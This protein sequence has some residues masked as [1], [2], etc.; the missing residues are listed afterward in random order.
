MMTKNYFMQINP[1]KTLYY[2]FKWL[3]F[4]IAK[5]MPILI[6][7]N[8]KLCNHRGGVILNKDIHF[9]MIN[10]GFHI[11]GFRNKK[12]DTFLVIRG[13][14]IFNGHC[15]IGKGSKIIIDKKGR[16]EFGKNFN[17][18]AGLNMECK[19]HVVFGD[20][21]V[22]SWDITIL[23]TDF[24]PI[25]DEH[26]KLINPNK[27]IQIGNHVWIGYN[28]KILKGITIPDNVIIASNTIVSKSVLQSGIIVGNEEYQLNKL[29][30]NI[31]W[32]PTDINAE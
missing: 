32:M 1:F 3:P 7:W 26:Q 19:K 11:G 5:K 25:Y 13:Q 28:T 24:H 17:C 12:D 21:C 27:P 23:D 10:L 14:A 15:S 18:T 6:A 2:N 29:K 16:V 30:N 8:T 20:N 22:L 9:G 31:S 4:S